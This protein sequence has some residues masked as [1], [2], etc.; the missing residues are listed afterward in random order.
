MYNV[1]D[2][3]YT[4]YD[5]HVR[6]SRDKQAELTEYRDAN[7]ER[8]KNGLRK[9]ECNPPI[10]TYSQGSYAMSTMVQHPNNDYD[11]D[12]AVVFT[13]D[14]LPATALDARQLVLAGIVQGGGNFKQPPEARPNAVTVWYAEGHH[15]DLAV[16]RSSQDGFGNEITEHAGVDWTR[17]KPTEI[18]DWFKDE[19]TVKSPSPDFGATVKE[20]Q[21]RRIVQLLKMFARSRP[22]WKL[23]GGLLISALVAECYRSNAHFDD[24]A[25]YDTMAAIR[26]RLQGNTEILNP[27]D[28]S[29]KLTYKD[30]YI[31]QV[32]CFEE[33][34]GQ[35]LDWLGPLSQSDCDE[36]KAYQA[37]SAVFRHDY[38]SALVDG[39]QLREAAKSLYVISS[40]EIRTEK[41]DVSAVPSPPHRFYGD[42]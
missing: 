19:V 40:G 14:D 17:R 5:R 18:A 41:P 36:R 21:M 2:E 26:V 42:A 32:V 28:P 33:K 22:S 37:W 7:I 11:L 25:L 23:P 29:Q 34:L 13:A 9:L 12:T 3:M 15:I 6:L 30:K 39:V 38:W 4:F 16:Y 31:N 35:A 27:V 8:L 20:G 1:Y 10:R 24:A